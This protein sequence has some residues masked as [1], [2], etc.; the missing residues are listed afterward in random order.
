ML[1]NDGMAQDEAKLLQRQAAAADACLARSM[2]DEEAQMPHLQHSETQGPPRGGGLA[3]IEVEEDWRKSWCRLQQAVP[4][5]R[6]LA[7]RG[8]GY[9]ESEPQMARMFE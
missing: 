6:A 3:E 5:S 8:L 7:L 1:L 4:A 2:A 9:E